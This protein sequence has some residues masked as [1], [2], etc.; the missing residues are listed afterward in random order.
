MYRV[1]RM[2]LSAE[3]RNRK[4]DAGNPRSRS[5]RRM[6]GWLTGNMKG[7]SALACVFAS[8][9]LA[10]PLAAHFRVEQ[11]PQAVYRTSVELVNVVFTVTDR[12]GKTVSGLKADD[13]QVF[14]DK[15]QQKIDYFNDWTRGSEAP[16]TVALLVDTSGSVKSKLSYEKQTAAEFFKEVLR[17]NRDLALVIQFDSDVSLVQDLTEDI[18]RLTS[19]LETLRAGNSTSLYDAIYLAVDEKLKDEVG[20]KVIVII[21]DGTDTSSKMTERDAIEAAQ[22]NDVLIYGIG[23]RGD[24][25]DSFRVLEKFAAETGG[26]FFSPGARMSEIRNAFHS[27]SQDLQGQ[28]SLAYRSTNQT[29]DGSFRTIE[30]RCKA[31]GVRI[32]AR[33]GYYAP[34][35][36]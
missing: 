4:Q 29:H 23:V 12:N 36:D 34:K 26:C 22:R 25:R 33:K 30:V 8:L 9:A 17:K 28:Y 27:I 18:N 24:V 19:A 10:A 15:K 1:T 20:R 3:T 13:F 32:R 2:L 5:H 16:L 7:K 35:A 31:P 6:M 14:E 11:Q 21:T